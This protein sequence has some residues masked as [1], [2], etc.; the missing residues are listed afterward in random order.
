MKDYQ[1]NTGR[2]TFQSSGKLLGATKAENILLNK[3][4]RPFSWFPEEASSARRDGDS[5][6]ALK[7]LGDTKKLE[8][9]SL[10]GKLI[11][12]LIKHTK[13]TFT[14]KEDLVD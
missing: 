1:K 14:T 12:N 4:S 5:N 2:K 9:N 8:G 10:F 3:S 11:E 7:R 13:T 6:P